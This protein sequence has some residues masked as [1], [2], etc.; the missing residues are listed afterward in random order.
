MKQNKTPKTPAPQEC[1]YCGGQD[2]A[3]TRSGPHRKLSCADCGQY[4]KFVNQDQMEELDDN[5]KLV[6]IQE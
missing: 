2:F 6:I 4:L 3:L 5:G 1:Q